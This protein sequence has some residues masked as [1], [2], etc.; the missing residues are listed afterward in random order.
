M[1][2][3]GFQP[4]RFGHHRWAFYALF[5]VPRDWFVWLHGEEGGSGRIAF[6]QVRLRPFVL[7]TI[8]CELG[9]GQ[10]LIG[11]SLDSLLAIDSQIYSLRVGGREEVLTPPMSAEVLSEVQTPGVD[12]PWWIDV[13]PAFGSG[14]HVELVIGWCPSALRFSP[15]RFDAMPGTLEV[16][17]QIVWGN[18]MAWEGPEQGGGG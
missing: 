5:S 9:P 13:P 15:S 4:C 1:N 17:R 3:L 16:A 6:H 11:L 8:E 18:G 14:Q 12:R 7:E 2:L 10:K